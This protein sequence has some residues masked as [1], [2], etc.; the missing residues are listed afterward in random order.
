MGMS[1][2]E[3]TLPTQLFTQKITD[4][5]I[6]ALCY[7]IGGGIMT[8]AGVDQRIHIHKAIS[9]AKML[10]K[11]QGLYG[12]YIKDMKLIDKVGAVYNITASETDLNGGDKGVIVDSGTTDTYL[13]LA[14]LKKFAESFK[15]A[16]GVNFITPGPGPTKDKSGTIKLSAEQLESLPTIVFNL[17]TPTNTTIEVS[18]P[19]SSYV[20][21]VGDGKYAFRVYLSERQGG[22]LGANFMN[23]Y[24]VVF[25]A[26]NKRIG[27]AKSNCN[28]EEYAPVVTATPTPAPTKYPGELIEPEPA[29][30]PTLYLPYTQCTA[31]CDRNES[32]YI[33]FGKQD[34]ISKCLPND[35]D[36]ISKDCEEHCS[37]YK[38]TKGD[39]L[40]PDTPWSECSHACIVARFA[41]PSTEPT[42]SHGKCSYK[43]QTST[44]Y[45][46]MCPRQDGDYLLYV[47]MR[48]RIE[49]FRWSYVYTEAFFA[50][51]ATIFKVN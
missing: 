9:Y 43:Q 1:N 48:V 27:F 42:M 50:A 24:N 36:F 14:L 3:E 40:C 4:S 25:D 10:P 32:H 46:G 31:R 16:S 34:Y 8:I 37:F 51:F 5:K 13:S 2:S 12:V 29:C 17:L 18:M 15:K 20:D 21:S 49:P 22:V 41:I 7:R 47:D 38:V 44:C 33:A 26:S 19:M 30:D 35:A 28:Y 23:N 39:I 11:P 6:F 45:T